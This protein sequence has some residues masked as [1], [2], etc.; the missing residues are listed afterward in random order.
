MQIMYKD[1]TSQ[2]AVVVV[3][4]SAWSPSTQ[5]NEVESC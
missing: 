1:I 5:T 2:W 3:K 4:L